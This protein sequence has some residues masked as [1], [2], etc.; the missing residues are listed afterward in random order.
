MGGVKKK[1]VSLMLL[2]LQ[3]NKDLHQILQEW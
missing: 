3:K 1:F 2:T